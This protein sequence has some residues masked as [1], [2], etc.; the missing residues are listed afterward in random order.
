[1]T[2]STSNSAKQEAIAEANAHLN[3]VDLPNVYALAKA[4]NDLATQY[5][6]VDNFARMSKAY[7]NATQLVDRLRDHLP[8][9]I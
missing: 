2:A 4:L 9:N 7:I 3:N 6:T 8:G 1:M 5:R